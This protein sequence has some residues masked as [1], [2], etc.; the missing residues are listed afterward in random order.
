MGPSPFTNLVLKVFQ[1]NYTSLIET[2][3]FFLS[4][5]LVLASA[6]LAVASVRRSFLGWPLAQRQR[7]D[8]ASQI[9]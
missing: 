1:Y 4:R 7:Q 2:I 5:I 3:M 9:S 8:N 6:W